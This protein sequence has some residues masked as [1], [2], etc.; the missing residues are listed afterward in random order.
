MRL[1]ALLAFY[2]IFQSLY[3]SASLSVSPSCCLLLSLSSVLSLSLS[4]PS[5]LLCLR[6]LM[7]QGRLRAGRLESEGCL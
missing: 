1:C 4:L 5:F 6:L 7:C 3:L 2:F